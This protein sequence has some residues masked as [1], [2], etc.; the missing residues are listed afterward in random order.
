MSS[1]MKSS[2][3]GPAALRAI[4]VAFRRCSASRPPIVSPC[5]AQSSQLW[6]VRISS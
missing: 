2:A 5:W 4:A 3:F 1:Q 6:P